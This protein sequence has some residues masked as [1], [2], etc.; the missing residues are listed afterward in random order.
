W[1]ALDGSNTNICVY[2]IGFW[3]QFLLFEDMFD[4]IKLNNVICFPFLQLKEMRRE[5]LRMKRVKTVVH[6]ELAGDRASKYVFPPQYVVL[7]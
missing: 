3:V 2:A 5:C 4:R 1:N 6:N 7:G